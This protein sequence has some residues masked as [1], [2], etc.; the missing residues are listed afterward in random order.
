MRATTGTGLAA[1]SECR[2]VLGQDLRLGQVLRARS[3]IGG[4]PHRWTSRLSRLRLESA[5]VRAIDLYRGPSLSGV[6]P[7][8]LIDQL[9]SADVA[10]VLAAELHRGR[11]P[12]R[13]ESAEVRASE[14]TGK[15]SSAPR[16]AAAG[17]RL[18]G[19]DNADR[20]WTARDK[21]NGAP[22][23]AILRGLVLRTGQE[24]HCGARLC[25]PRRAPEG[26]QLGPGGKPV[27]D[28]A[29]GPRWREPGQ[30]RLRVPWLPD[31]CCGC[32]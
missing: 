9:P 15:G 24:S 1:K 21:P 22:P 2:S 19:T 11:A 30:R 5:T 31:S 3:K 17:R 6:G 13:P 29:A 18:T 25:G 4:C 28:L 10:A 27:V 32:W 14:A 23:D 12:C 7:P 26:C 8:I 16:P 20:A